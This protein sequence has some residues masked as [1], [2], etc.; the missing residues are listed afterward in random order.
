MYKQFTARFHWNDDCDKSTVRR[1]VLMGGGRDLLSMKVKAFIFTPWVRAD[2]FFRISLYYV[3]F[4]IY[5]EA[6]SAF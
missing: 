4:Q 2:Q 3:L 6:I 5:F 1:L